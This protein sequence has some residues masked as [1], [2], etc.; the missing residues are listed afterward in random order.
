MTFDVFGTV[1]NWRKSLVQEG[2]H[3]GQVS[4]TSTNWVDVAQRWAQHYGQ[5]VRDWQRRGP[6]GRWRRLDVVL[7]EFGKN[8]L[9]ELKI[10]KLPR[11][12]R[13][14]WLNAWSRLDPW[15]DAVAGLAALRS[16]FQIA[17][18]SNANEELG[19]AIAK[20]ARLPWHKIIAPDSVQEYKPDPR[21]YCLA[22]RRL[23]L[24]P[25]EVMMVAAHLYDLE[26]A[27]R[28]GFKT[29]FVRRPNE[30]L[31]NPI[32]P[33]VDVIAEDLQDLAQ[34]ANAASTTH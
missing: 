32:Q 7:R 20:H 19:R 26:G 30:E 24:E 25:H 31:N 14:R 27:Q 23:R 9:G 33:F 29:A 8:M 17:A 1:V 22:L 2:E 5:H 34:Q 15:D 16:R 21:V 4:N 3:L 18:L 12:Q 28:I 13:D 10:V 6:G 11:V